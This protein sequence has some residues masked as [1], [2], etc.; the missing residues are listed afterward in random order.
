MFLRI[1]LPFLASLFTALNFAVLVT[2][3]YAQTS[4]RVAV[5]VNGVQIP[6]SLIEEGVK[7][8][9][10][11]GQAD[12]P[13]L[14]KAIIENLINR[15]LLSQAALKDG[16]DKTPEARLQLNQ[17]R[18]NL[19]A[20][21]MLL[22]YQTK[23]PISDAEV[24]AEYD[25]QVADFGK[26][27]S[28]MEEY[29]LSIIGVASN[30][31]ANAILASLKSGASFDQLAREKSVDDTKAQ[32]GALGWLLLSQVSPT[33]STAI[34]SLPKDATITAPIQT[35]T[36]WYI[37]KVDDK[38]PFKVP[39]LAESQAQIKNALIQEKFRQYLF[40]LRSA[41]KITL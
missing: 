36:A 20:E 10:A 18:Q 13:E 35:P 21:M 19:M 9:L 25:R 5:T 39:S 17:L 27:P 29:K 1:P 32:G 14:R 23:H 15:E 38:R 22:D 7:L 34:S 4:A 24:K 41:A 33:L 40:E 26:N 16:L 8:N 6:Q 2:P 28:S 3:G 37:V 30:A 31:D 11:R 12:T